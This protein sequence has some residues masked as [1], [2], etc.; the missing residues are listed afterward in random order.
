M[1]VVVFGS[2]NRDLVM[3]V[4]RLPLAGETVAARGLDL[5]PGGKGANQATASAL[6]GVPTMLIGAVGDDEHGAAMRA[7]MAAA[8]VDASL[9]QNVAGPTGVANV[10]VSDEGE[11]QIVIVA[12]ANAHVAAPEAFPACA[13]RAVAVAQAEV[14][15][16]QVARFFAA[17]RAAGALTLFNPAPASAEGAD[18]IALADVVVLNETELAF[19]VGS[20][21]P[22]GDAAVEAAA[23]QL[24]SRRGQWVVVT[25]G[26][27][28]V[29]ACGPDET[30][31]LSAPRVPVVDTTGAGDTF[32]GV[33]AA[34]L[35]EGAGIGEALRVAC[36]AASL[37]VQRMGAAAS[38]PV[39]AEVEAALVVS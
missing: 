3:R 7:A 9:V 34:R 23:R 2:I 8:G 17:A 16:A 5:L 6:H 15:A 20:A 13:G 14:P 1:T 30:L 33:L 29:L 25:L 39:R 22:D 21:V 10:F 26:G 36:V 11:N 18:L 32:C 28:G 24:V 35:S 19:F 38:M 4:P 27:A 31:R 37:S 12:G